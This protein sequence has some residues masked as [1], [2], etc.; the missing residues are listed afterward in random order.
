[1]FV[2]DV[3]SRLI[4]AT[5]EKGQDLCIGFCFYCLQV[6]LDSTMLISA[7]A[8]FNLWWIGLHFSLTSLN[9]MQAPWLPCLINLCGRTTRAL[10]EFPN[11]CWQWDGVCVYL[12]CFLVS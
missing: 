11:F 9:V 10:C 6:S 4:C 7:F 8:G 12:S 2:C 5:T 3:I 1:M